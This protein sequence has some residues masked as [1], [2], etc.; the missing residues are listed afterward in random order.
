MRKPLFDNTATL[1]DECRS[2]S[3]NFANQIFWKLVKPFNFVSISLIF[4]DGDKHFLYNFIN[5]GDSE[6]R[7]IWLCHLAL[8]KTRSRESTFC[9]K[10]VLTWQP[11]TTT[12]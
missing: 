10:L 5:Q 12:T 9:G 2:N 7:C 11:T 6:I 1:S 8:T 4:M 3:D